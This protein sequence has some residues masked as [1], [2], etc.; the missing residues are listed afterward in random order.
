MLSHTAFLVRGKTMRDVDPF[1]SLGKPVR[2]FEHFSSF[3]RPMLKG[4]RNRELEGVQPSKMEK[5]RIL[6]A[7]KRLHEFLEKEADQALRGDFARV[8]RDSCTS[9]MVRLLPASEGQNG[10]IQ[11]E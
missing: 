4:K 2:D 11:R 10:A 9:S 5:E 7:Q 6:S 8:A 1:S 3:E